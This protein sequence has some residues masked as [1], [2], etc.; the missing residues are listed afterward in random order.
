M[1]EGSEVFDTD[2]DET[3]VE[4]SVVESD[5]EEKEFRAERLSL[6]DKDMVW[7]NS[8]TSEVANTYGEMLSPNI[9]FN[10]I[11][12]HAHKQLGLFNMPYQQINEMEESQS[13]L[14]I[15]IKSA[16]NAT[17]IGQLDCV[18]AATV[19]GEYKCI[20]LESK[21]PGVLEMSHQNND[22]L[23][24]SLLSNMDAVKSFS[25]D[26]PK[27]LETSVTFQSGMISGKNDLADNDPFHEAIASNKII[28]NIV[29]KMFGV[30]HIIEPLDEIETNQM[31]DILACQ[32][33]I[34][35]IDT[36]VNE[37]SNTL[38]VE[39]L[40][41]LNTLTESI[42][43]V[44]DRTGSSTREK[45]L[46]P[47]DDDD[48]REIIETDLK[49]QCHLQ[50]H[51]EPKA[52][53]IAKMSCTSGEHTDCE[54]CMHPLCHPDP[55]KTDCSGRPSKKE[56]SSLK[57]IHS[58]GHLFEGTSCTLRKSA[59][60]RKSVAINDI[61]AT[62]NCQPFLE[63]IHQKMHSRFNDKD[64]EY[65]SSQLGICTY[66]CSSSDA[67]TK[68]KQV[69]KSQRI[70]KKTSNYISLSAINRRDAFG[71]TLLH[72]A[73]T[74]DDLD[75]VCAMIKAGWTPLHEASL[76]GCFEISNELL[77]AGADVNCKGYEQVTPLHEAVKEGHYKASLLHQVG[78]Q[79]TVMSLWLLH[80][81]LEM[82]CVSV[83]VIDVLLIFFR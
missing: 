45:Q 63:G 5:L 2:S 73:A 83:Q 77:K 1:M 74:E 47:E 21:V 27:Y 80:Y 22:P 70:A 79:H 57:D 9:P 40:T 16:V 49:S 6:V 52:L 33:D 4:G 28:N 53:T 67:N 59:H 58:R 41:A 37:E 32:N 48:V 76:A 14:P 23:E 34:F 31:S 17:N 81:V 69:R 62:S 43:A 19:Y 39:L 78:V 61:D 71:Q 36:S 66:H 55:Q 20:G 3:I 15:E 30:K 42:G 11:K 13:L 29:D 38:P 18:S 44:V 82:D 54:Q 7:E 26:V 65:K 64:K 24:K 50:C 72:R 51:E 10:C 56:N 12:F 75:G 35:S 8:I 25:N 68:I 46:T 60:E